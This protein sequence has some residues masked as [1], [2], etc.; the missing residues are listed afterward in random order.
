MPRRRIFAAALIAALL[1][2]FPLRVA[3]AMVGT[4]LSAQLVSGFVWGGRAVGAQVVG[5]PLGD[6]KIGL[7]PLHLLLG[8]A[9][10][11]LDGAIKG[12]LVDG[13]G[14]SGVDIETMNLPVSKGFGPVTISQIEM[15]DAH[16]RMNRDSC[17]EADGRLQIVLAPNALPMALSGRFTGNLKCDGKAIGSLL[18]S[19][20]AMERIVLRVEPSGQFEA[21]LITRAADDTAATTLRAAGFKETAAGFSYKLAGVF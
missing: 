1:I 11:K 19:Q 21:T 12:A 5:L 16:I 10:L 3:L 15:S 20:S 14:G 7:S 9:K 4:P 13:I 18:I 8:R 2:I 6:L 17:K